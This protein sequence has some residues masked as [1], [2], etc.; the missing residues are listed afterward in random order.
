[1]PIT[2][3]LPA[4]PEHLAISFWQ[5]VA[6]STPNQCWLW[7]GP[8]R[9][10]YGKWTTPE[11]RQLMAHRVAFLLH[12]K[13]DP[14]PLLVCHKCDNPPCCNPYHLFAGTSA[15][16]QMDMAQKMRGRTQRKP[17]MTVAQVK[18]I[19]RLY[20]E[21]GVFQSDIAQRFQVSLGTVSGIIRG[22][23]WKSL[24]LPRPPIRNH[25]RTPRGIANPSGKL[26]DEQ[27][28]EIRELYNVGA[29]SQDELAERFQ[30]TQSHVSTLVRHEQR[31]TNTPYNPQRRYIKRK[32]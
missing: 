2:Q 4:I 16:N 14:F 25:R 21:E 11:G 32:T 15:D 1:M 13:H 19:H 10:E 26:T 3:P 5:L 9:K 20:T 29:A 17:I 18:E 8:K 22:T 28:Q 24:Q 27:V 31:S 7:L 23:L 6:I 30:I 12:Y